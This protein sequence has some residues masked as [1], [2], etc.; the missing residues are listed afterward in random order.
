MLRKITL[1]GLSF[2]SLCWQMAFSQQAN[3]IIDQ[4]NS[5]CVNECITVSDL[6]MSPVNITNW[7]WS[8]TSTVLD[9]P[10]IPNPNNQ[11]PGDICFTSPG[12]FNIQLNITDVNGNVSNANVQ[13][14]VVSC[15]GS[16]SAGFTI[17]E[18]VCVGDCIIANDTSQGSPQ[19]WNWSLNVLPVNAAYIVNSVDQNPT[20]C[21]TSTTAAPIGIELKVTD[22][23]G[24]VSKFTKQ[25]T[26]I[27]VPTVVASIDTI[28]ELGD[29]AFLSATATSPT[30]LNYQWEPSQTATNPRGL[31]TNVY[32]IET[33]SYSI[34]VEN[35]YGCSAEDSV[36]VYL[37]FQPKIGVSSAFSPN[38]DGKND[39]L[40]V[41]GLA[42]EV[43]IFKVYNRWGDKI[44]ES[45][46]Q[47]NGWDGNYKGKAE[48]PGVYYWT[49]EYGFNNGQEGTLSG[50]TTLIR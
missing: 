21:F 25:I 41:E 4:G 11:V 47:K 3:F 28:V 5:I 43:C 40:L 20:I 42:L 2:F 39:L 14:T 15:P 13:L 27:D 19:A 31:T 34:K 24:K 7:V 32:P 12:V 18:T 45:T 50:N 35:S 17:Q 22:V 8:I 38:G 36:I 48:S 9:I 23:N 30:K 46:V 16:I 33:T 10:S 37:N 49:L 1:I 44:F 26:V 29:P 6:S